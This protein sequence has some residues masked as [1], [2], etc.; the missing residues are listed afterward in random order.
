[1]ALIDVNSWIGPYPWRHV[2][3]PEPE[4][5][6]RVLAREGIAG[7]W[8]G[9]L[10]SAFWRDPSPG[11]AELYAAVASHPTLHP[12]PCVRPD[13]PGWEAQLD[14]AVAR[15]A[16]A[17]RAYPQCWGFAPGDAAMQRLLAACG[18]RG[19]V[20]VLTVR[21][22]DLRQRHPLDATPD[23]TAAHLR[24]LARAVQGAAARAP[25]VVCHAGRELVEE[26]VWSLTDAERE[27]LFF[28]FSWIWGPPE[29][30]LAAL[31]R[32]VGA[33]RFTYGTGWPLRLTQNPAA[34]LALL[35]GD[36]RALG[37]R[38]A[39]GAAIAARARAAA[40]R[41]RAPTPERSDAASVDAAATEAGA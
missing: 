21:F 17:V 1:M 34:L 4:V 32:T 24:P 39:D 20:L 11:N 9:H 26:T 30:Q 31:L 27:R 28:D 8:V 12:A 2:P 7:A 13:W 29:D 18:E 16:P 14:E 41:S 6:V 10:P 35:P 36:V 33:E 3:H 37:A 22:E 23:L 5:L 40:T 19:L 25:I 15:G 38:L